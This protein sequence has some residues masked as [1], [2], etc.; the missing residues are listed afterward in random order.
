MS[1]QERELVVIGT[2]YPGIENYLND[3]VASL[4]R[5]T[6]RNFDVL[7][8]NDGLYKF[9]LPSLRRDIRC[10]V[11]AVGGSIS[12]NRRQS[13]RHALALGYDKIIFTDC[14]DAFDSNR[15][16]L[17]NELLETTEIV[18]ND[19]DL[20]DEGGSLS[21]ANYLSQ[22]FGEAATISE[23]L[24]RNANLMGL[25]N[26]AAK[27]RVFQDLPALHHGE[28]IA[29]D[30]YLWSCALHEGFQALFTSKTST[31]YRVYADNI[32]GMPQVLDEDKIHTGIKVKCRHYRL[33][34]DV[35]GEYACLHHDFEAAKLKWN[36]Q[37]WR[38]EYVS[39]L[40]ATA[41][42]VHLWWENIRTP[43]EVGLT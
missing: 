33:M 26:T 8:A 43:A 21:V 35:A 13:I 17:V 20:I 4:N 18:V 42:E 10:T 3:Y 7:L 2:L 12:S 41:V 1:K 23:Q 5:Q 36:D 40:K 38:E 27:A 37:D 39:R 25:S 32:A 9:N 34:S 19:L 11:T 6:A 16:S 15:I 28:A 14:D 29:F 30:W 24:L 22:R 31:H